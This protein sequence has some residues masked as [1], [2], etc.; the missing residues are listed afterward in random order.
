MANETNDLKR[1]LDRF[2]VTIAEMAR[3]CDVTSDYLA[4]ITRGEAWPS[5]SMKLTIA[6]QSREHEASL[7]VAVPH[8]VPAA[9]WITALEA[10]ALTASDGAV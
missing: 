2:G 1:W 10:R 3:R 6:R 7:G 5:D 9:Y 8:G 4:R